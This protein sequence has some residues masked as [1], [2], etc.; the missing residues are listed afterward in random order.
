MHNYR[1]PDICILGDI[2]KKLGV[3]NYKEYAGYIYKYDNFKTMCENSVNKCQYGGGKLIIKYKDMDFEFSK[4]RD[5]D[6][7]MIAL[8]VKGNI[9]CLLIRINKKEKMA[10]ILGIGYYPYC[11][12]N[13]QI[14]HFR[15]KTGGSLL[16]RLALKIVEEIK[17]QYKIEKITLQDN[18][19]K[20]CHENQIDLSKMYILMYGETWYGNYG[21]IPYDSANGIEHKFGIKKYGKNKDI[22]NKVKVKDVPQLKKYILDSYNNILKNNED[23]EDLMLK[24]EEL[25]EM[26]NKYKNEDRLLKDFIKK[27]LVKYD[28]TCLLF[29]AFY[30]ALFDDLD[31]ADFH[32]KY[33]VKYVQ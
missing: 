20:L 17:D 18:S 6:Y 15:G 21:F 1:K 12:T 13:E 5:E 14:K 32:G 3:A 2:L 29:Y 28:K 25:M 19:H 7:T 24:K 22:M 8:T 23:V 30:E 16:L 26:Y 9:D 4:Y 10:E 31:L 11:F 27:F 33:Y